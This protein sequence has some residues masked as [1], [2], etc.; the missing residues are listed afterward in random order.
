MAKNTVD[1]L[2]SFKPKKAIG[3]WLF[4]KSMKTAFTRGSLALSAVAAGVGIGFW[5]PKFDQFRVVYVGAGVAIGLVILLTAL[6]SLLKFKATVIK[7][8]AILLIGGAYL[9]A[10]LYYI[11][12]DG[13]I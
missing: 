3:W 2:L 4:K 13:I 8:L 11:L 9:A 12:N 7:S 5:A 6:A 1:K 10:S